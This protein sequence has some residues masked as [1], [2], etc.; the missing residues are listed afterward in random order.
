MRY[1]LI[2]LM[3]LV[4]S[5]V[6]AAMPDSTSLARS[7]EELNSALISKDTMTLRRLLKDDVH[8]YHSNGWLQLRKDITMDL[9]NGK[10]TYKQI[11]TKSQN[12]RV[13]GNGGTARMNVDVDVVMMGKQLQFKLDVFQQWV[14]VNNGWKLVARK[15][16]KV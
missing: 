5:S 13:R 2:T 3:L 11:D 4:S 6:L 12:I 16:Q 14:W 8:Y 10:L 1:L 15:S 7:V 9:Y